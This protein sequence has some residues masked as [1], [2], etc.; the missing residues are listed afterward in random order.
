MEIREEIKVS[1]IWDVFVDDALVA[2][3]VDQGRVALSGTVGSAAE[4][5]RSVG[6][7]GIRGVRRVDATDLDVDPVDD[8][9]SGPTRP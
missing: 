5:T 9:C 1:L 2:V 8:E 7:A 4:K 6:V 3:D